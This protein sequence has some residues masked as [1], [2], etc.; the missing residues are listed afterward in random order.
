MVSEGK[1]RERG[2]NGKGGE[3]KGKWREGSRACDV[4]TPDHDQS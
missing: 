4:I 3:E 2:A 1:G